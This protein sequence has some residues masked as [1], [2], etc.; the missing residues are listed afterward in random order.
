[1]KLE[2][3]RGLA[4]LSDHLIDKDGEVFLE[5][6]TKEKYEFD[7]SLKFAVRDNNVLVLRTGQNHDS[8][9]D[10]TYN[11]EELLEA[12]QKSI[13]TDD[14]G[15]L[16]EYLSEGMDEGEF[17]FGGDDYHESQDAIEDHDFD[18]IPEDLLD[19]DSGEIDIEK[20]QDDYDFEVIEEEGKQISKFES[21]KYKTDDGEVKIDLN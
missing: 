9:W 14:L 11:A 4:K 13:E 17:L 12:V 19:E 10:Y 21:F 2:T 3:K 1:M 15:G 7:R 8:Y 20:L 16:N 18:E 6:Y 5:L